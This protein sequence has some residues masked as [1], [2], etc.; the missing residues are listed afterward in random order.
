MNL[1]FKFVKCQSS[2]RKENP[3]NSTAALIGCNEKMFPIVRRHLL[4]LI[5]SP[6]TNS[7]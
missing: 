5:I 4:I 2:D 6:V 3:E 1:N 7:E